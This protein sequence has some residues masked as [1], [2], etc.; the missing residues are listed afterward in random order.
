MHCR[1]PEYDIN[2]FSK[3]SIPFSRPPGGY[4]FAKQNKTAGKRLFISF[5]HFYL[6]A[7]MIRSDGLFGQ[8]VYP[9]KL[10]SL[11]L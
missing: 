11:W 6:P 7:R 8:I 9:Q 10:L 5:V 2:Q 1:L 3:E 4:K